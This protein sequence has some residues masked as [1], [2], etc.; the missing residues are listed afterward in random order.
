[1]AVVVVLADGEAIINPTEMGIETTRTECMNA[2][3]VPDD[4]REHNGNDINEKG[5]GE[6]AAMPSLMQEN[7]TGA[8]RG[9][10][11]G[12]AVRINGEDN[13]D[14]SPPLD[15]LDHGNCD[16]TNGD[17]SCP[18]PPDGNTDGKESDDDNVSSSFRGNRF[19]HIRRTGSHNSRYKY[20]I[21]ISL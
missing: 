4:H 8:R 3:I 18:P 12:G 7:E 2:V 21:L 20:Q 11:R 1:M 13:S 17:R 14:P 6:E 16:I 15:H 19:L 10:G 5:G 9:D